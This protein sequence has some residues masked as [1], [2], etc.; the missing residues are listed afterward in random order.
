MG[1]LLFETFMVLKMCILQYVY[2]SASDVTPKGPNDDLLRSKDTPTQ[3]AKRQT[4]SLNDI[5]AACDEPN[6]PGLRTARSV[7]CTALDN[8]LIQVGK[9]E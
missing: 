6:R 3:S 9:I 8:G 4:Q 1:S 7:S 5:P 2:S